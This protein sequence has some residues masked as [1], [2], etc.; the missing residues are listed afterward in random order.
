[1]G[2]PPVIIVIFALLMLLLF[3]PLHSFPFVQILFLECCHFFM[4]E[5][6]AEREKGMVEG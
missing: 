6:G 3:I 5:E 1:M 4:G 2:V